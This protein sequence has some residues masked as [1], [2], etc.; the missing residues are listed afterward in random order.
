MSKEAHLERG[1]H[2]PAVEAPVYVN[3]RRIVQ[4]IHHDILCHFHRCLDPLGNQ[5]PDDMFAFGALAARYKE[6]VGFRSG[7]RF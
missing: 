6:Q 5:A 7:Q 4:H 3:K 2:S 1:I